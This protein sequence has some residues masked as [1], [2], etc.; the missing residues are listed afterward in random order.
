M[1]LTY[2]VYGL[3]PTTPS[4]VGNGASDLF[5]EFTP[6]NSSVNSG[7]IG[8]GDCREDFIRARRVRYTNS[9]RIDLGE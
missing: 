4:F 9:H 7:P 2:D 3:A 8:D 1:T 6:A 5:R